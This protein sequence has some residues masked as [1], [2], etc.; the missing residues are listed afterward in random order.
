MPYKCINPLSHLTTS[1]SSSDPVRKP[2]IKIQ[3]L[4]EVNNSCHLKLSCEISGQSANYTWYGNSGPLPTDLQSP[5]LEITVY[6]QNFSSYYTCQASNPVSSKNDTIYF[7][8][9]CKLGKG[10]LQ[11]VGRGGGECRYGVIRF[12]LNE[13]NEERYEDPIQPPAQME[14]PKGVCET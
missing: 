8:S 12:L 1:S 5:V 3:T 6:R 10:C 11:G 13:M 2:G 14:D 4:Q 9:L 7:S